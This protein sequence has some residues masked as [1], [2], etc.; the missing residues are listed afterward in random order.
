MPI[1]FRYVPDLK[2]VVFVHEGQVADEEFSSSYQSFFDR[3]GLDRFCNYLV[4]LRHADSA[5]RSSEALRRLARY[6]LEKH[7]NSPV[8]INIAV[9]APQ[10]VSFGLARM[11]EV[12]SCGVPWRFNVFR[13]TKPALEW[14]DIPES[15][16]DQMQPGL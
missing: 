16:I 12:F 14:L 2:L 6:I 4:D 3:P 11:F 13:E 8:E 1:I 5:P 15:I 7:G 9:V 10:N